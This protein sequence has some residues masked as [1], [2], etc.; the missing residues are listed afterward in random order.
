M[1][2]HI[3]TRT[4]LLAPTQHGPNTNGEGE[5]SV[6]KCTLTCMTRGGSWFEGTLCYVAK[7]KSEV[8][9]CYEASKSEMSSGFL[10]HSRFLGLK[11]KVRNCYPHQGV[12]IV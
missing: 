11:H 12:Y 9:T 6:T 3:L 7:G 10:G 4:R 8:R 5:W 1:I 2:L